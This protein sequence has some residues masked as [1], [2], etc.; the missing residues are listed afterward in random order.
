MTLSLSP[1]P[2]QPFDQVN[3]PEVVQPSTAE[4][5]DTLARRLQ[6]QLWSGFERLQWYDAY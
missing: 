6:T 4:D 1:S 3:T 5:A 2:F